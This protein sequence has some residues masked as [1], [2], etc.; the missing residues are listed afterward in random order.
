MQLVVRRDKAN[1]A[2]EVDVA[3]AAASAVVTLLA[4]GAAPRRAL[5]RGRADLAG[6]A[7][8]QARAP[9][10]TASAGRTSS[11]SPRHGRCAPAGTTITAGHRARVRPGPGA[12]P[13]EN[14]T[15]CRSPERSSRQEGRHGPR[16]PW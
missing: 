8:P 16:T 2:R 13:A 6:R 7:D 14:C 12:S 15:S 11:P 9:R 10:G 3:E 4:D 1:P 5:A